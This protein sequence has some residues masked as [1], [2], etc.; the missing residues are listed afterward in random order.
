MIAA[1]S[2][3]V[4]IAQRAERVR[5]VP[6]SS[7]DGARVARMIR[8]PVW[9]PVCRQHYTLVVEASQWQPSAGVKHVLCDAC[10]GGVS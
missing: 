7:V 6:S 8:R 3:Y 2:P 4:P 10:F 9:C 1:R 5:L